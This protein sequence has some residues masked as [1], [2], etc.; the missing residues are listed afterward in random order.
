MRVGV[1]DVKRLVI[2]SCLI[3][4]VSAMT[5]SRNP[6]K[7]DTRSKAERLSTARRLGW[8]FSTVF[9]ISIRWSSTPALS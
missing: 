1:V 6:L 4:E 2:S 8:N 7:V 3:K 9:F 5:N